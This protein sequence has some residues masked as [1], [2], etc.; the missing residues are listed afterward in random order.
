MEFL[1][2]HTAFFFKRGQQWPTVALELQKKRA[3]MALKINKTL[4]E[5]RMLSSVTI[6]CRITK[7]V[8]N[9]GSLLSEL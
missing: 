9:S 2:S 6:N 7:I 8:I 5:L 4:Q 3:E 1:R